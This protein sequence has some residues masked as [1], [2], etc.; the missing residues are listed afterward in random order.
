MPLTKIL[1]RDSPS[2][3]FF[4]PAE[5]RDPLTYSN[6]KMALLSRETGAELAF[7]APQKALEGEVVG[8]VEAPT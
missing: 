1:G 3:S 8:N 5:A 2:A 6:R 7:S 4:L